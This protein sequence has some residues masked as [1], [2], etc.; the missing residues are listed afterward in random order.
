[1]FSALRQPSACKVVCVRARSCKPRADFEMS[2]SLHFVGGGSSVG[3]RA[4]AVNIPTQPSCPPAYPAGCWCHG[5]PPMTQA[6]I[7]CD[8]SEA[9]QLIARSARRSVARARVLGG[10]GRGPSGVQCVRRGAPRGRALSSR[11]WAREMREPA[12]PWTYLCAATSVCDGCA[13]R[14]WR[15][16]RRI[17]GFVAAQVGRAAWVGCRGEARPV[18]RVR[19]ALLDHRRRSPRTARGPAPRLGACCLADGAIPLLTG[20]E[21]G[22]Q[23]F[24][25][26]S[27]V[28][29]TAWRGCWLCVT[30]LACAGPLGSLPPATAGVLHC[31]LPSLAG[32]LER[33]ASRLIGCGDGLDG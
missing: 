16:S 29:C 22:S 30:A 32:D 3:S 12:T 20:P 11:A 23:F 21:G 2:V 10:G 24:R 13:V 26:C 19:D 9:G 7:G 28:G 17:G 1:M 33:S 15:D 4:T 5:E 8:V 27:V 14:V 25:V 6:S 31:W 18:A